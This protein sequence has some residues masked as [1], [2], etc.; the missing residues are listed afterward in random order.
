MDAQLA[1]DYAD[2]VAARGRSAER[3]DAVP[4]GTA[5]ALGGVVPGAIA[6]VTTDPS[7]LGALAAE[8]LVRCLADA[9]VVAGPVL[10]LAGSTQV[11]DSAAATLER[12]GYTASPVIDLAGQPDPEAAFTAGYAEANG[13]IVGVIA[14]DDAAAAAAV[15]GLEANAQAGKVPVVGYGVGPQTRA[16]LA[17]GSQCAA[18]RPAVK[19]QSRLAVDLAQALESGAEVSEGAPDTVVSGGDALAGILVP[20]AFAGTGNEGE[21]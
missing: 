8:S 10:L 11:R 9:G 13:N 21:R 3:A 5:I 18:L 20:P 17:D 12:S 15:S 2:A 4:V 7:A 19:R 16:R 14:D 1:A 6:A